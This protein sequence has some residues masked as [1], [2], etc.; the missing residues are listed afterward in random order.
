ME[1]PGALD[2]VE[3][4]KDPRSAA[5]RRSVGALLLLFLA[6]LITAITVLY[7]ISCTTGIHQS[8]FVFRFDFDILNNSTNLAPYS[9]IPTFLAVATKAWFGSVGDALKMFQP[10]ISLIKAPVPVSSSL[11]VEYINTPIALASIKAFRNSHWVLTSVALGALATEICE[12]NQHFR[13]F[14]H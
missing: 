10:Y 13:Y 7:F 11:L 4:R 12:Y 14:V 8:P 2:L 3:K 1:L 6:T 9:I 5:L